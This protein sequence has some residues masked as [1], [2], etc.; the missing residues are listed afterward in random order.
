MNTLISSQNVDL[1]EVSFS[2]LNTIKGGNG[3]AVAGLVIGVIKLAMDGCY[4]IGYAIGYYEA[5][6]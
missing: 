1:E 2:E 5:T 4:N 3:V 6:H